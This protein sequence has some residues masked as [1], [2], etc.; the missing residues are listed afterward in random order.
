MNLLKQVEELKNNPELF[1]EKFNNLNNNYSF[2]SREESYNFIKKH[3]GILLIIDAYT[4]YLQKYFPNGIFELTLNTDPEISNW[5]TLILT[6][7]VDKETYKNG[8]YEH[9]RHIRRMFWNIRTEL[10]LM[11]E[12]VLTSDVL[13]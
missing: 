6:V 4:P 3:P 10:N 2:E 8:C 1:E 5:K 11:S 7:K 12:L 9:I 13:R